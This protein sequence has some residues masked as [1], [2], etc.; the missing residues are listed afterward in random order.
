MQ[1]QKEEE[2]DL[3][4]KIIILGENNAGKT[5]L[6]ERIARDNF[7][8]QT[9]LTIGPESVIKNTRI[10][11]KVIHATIWEL[12]EDAHEQYNLP[13]RPSFN[14]KTRFDPCVM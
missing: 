3:Y 8:Y 4:F 9:M 2:I 1:N 14:T 12:G 11:N 7:P 5:C 10:D 6:L 13:K